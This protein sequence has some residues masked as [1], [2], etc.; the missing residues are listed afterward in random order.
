MLEKMLEKYKVVDSVGNKVGK[1]KDVYVDLD[2]WK[3]TAFEYSPGALKKD[4]VF[5]VSQISRMDHEEG[6]MIL[7][8]KFEDMDPPEKTK[9]E[10]YPFKEI[11][12]LQVV[13]SMGEKVGKVY[14]IDIPVEKLKDFKVWK[15]LIRVGIKDRRLRI[16]PQEISEIM[17]VIKL[18]NTLDQYKE[19]LE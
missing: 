18:K 5:M 1:L 15:L 10:M 17:G 13:D 2:S 8:D 3:G 9:R 16:S 11:Q 12:K 7:R 4:K 14:N 6:N 19:E